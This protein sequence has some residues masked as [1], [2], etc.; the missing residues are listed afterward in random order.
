ML[1]YKK[2]KCCIIIVGKKKSDHADYRVQ[3]FS[4]FISVF[5]WLLQIKTKKKT[6]IIYCPVRQMVSL[7]NSSRALIMTL[8]TDL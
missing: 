4:M 8:V 3:L 2:I 6:E 5:V 1:W 7:V